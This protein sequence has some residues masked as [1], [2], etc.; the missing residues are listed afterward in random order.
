[1]RARA[2]RKAA[3]GYFTLHKSS[4]KQMSGTQRPV[5]VVRDA[6]TTDGH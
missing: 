4:K 3:S 1:M 6:V 2:V 5:G